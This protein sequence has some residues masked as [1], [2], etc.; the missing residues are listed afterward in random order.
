MC[1]EDK[2]DDASDR[3]AANNE[4]YAL[5]DKLDL[6]GVP[7]RDGDEGAA[8]VIESATLEITTQVKKLISAVG[9][10]AVIAGAATSAWAALEDNAPL[11]VAIVAG[12][13][14]L[15]AALV[16]GLAKV[17]DGDVRG[18][19]SATTQQ[20]QSRADV[21]IKVLELEGRMPTGESPAATATDKPTIEDELRVALSGYGNSVKVTTEDG[22]GVV[23]GLQW[24][25]QK[26]LRVK[27]DTGE[28]VNLSEVKSFTTVRAEQAVP[29]VSD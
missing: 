10:I 25:D 14:V 21:A 13:A 19:A 17:V 11:A 15:L 20:I 2:K 6:V 22:P 8:G 7:Q 23:A 9:G 27:L 28:I 26:G 29:D 4:L 24:S 5:L 1:A 3:T 12:V 16:L 18:R